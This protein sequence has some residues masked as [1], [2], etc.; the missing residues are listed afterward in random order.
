M[1]K[2][3]LNVASATE[4][5]LNNCAVSFERPSNVDLQSVI[6]FNENVISKCN[7]TGKWDVFDSNLERMCLNPPGKQS[8]ASIFT[9]NVKCISVSKLNKSFIKSELV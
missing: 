3:H 2:E 4:F 6:C 1:S 7:E 5:I 8:N 9:L